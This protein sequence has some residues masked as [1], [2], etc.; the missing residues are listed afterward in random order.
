MRRAYQDMHTVYVLKSLTD[1]KT[2]LGC[3]KD[4]TEKWNYQGKRVYG[5]PTKNLIDCYLQG[6]V[7]VA[8]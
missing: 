8:E 6:E 1:G 7:N 3:T 2:Y 5:V 4:L